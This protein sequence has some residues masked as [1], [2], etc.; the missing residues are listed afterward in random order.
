MPH[1]YKDRLGKATDDI[2]IWR[3]EIV[4]IEHNTVFKVES[5]QKPSLKEINY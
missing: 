5:V 4:D 1:F 2:E 3:R